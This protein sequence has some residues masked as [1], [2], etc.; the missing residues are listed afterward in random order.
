M[1]FILTRELG[2]LSR[3][4]RI[5]GLDS[6]YET[7]REISKVI[8]KSLKEDRIILTKNKKF[9]EHPGLKCLVLDEDDYLEQLRR[10]VG[11]FKIRPQEVKMF[12]RCIFCNS[13]LVFVEKEKIKESV[14]PY[15]YQTQEEFY[16]CEKCGRIYWQGS[17]WGNVREVLDK[18]F[19]K[20]CS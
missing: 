12:S 6:L 3:W 9:L 20:K 18:V 17:H 11:E 2:R 10:V 7:A 5:L 13:P 19:S 14:P 1:K 15:V 4:L 16:M 8:V